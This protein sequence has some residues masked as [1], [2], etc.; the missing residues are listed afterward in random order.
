MVQVFIK[1]E[2]PAQ[3]FSCAICET[4]KNIFFAEHFRATASEPIKQNK[5]DVTLSL[6]HYT[7][8]CKQYIVIISAEEYSKMVTGRCPIKRC[9]YCK[10]HR[11][12][13]VPESLF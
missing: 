3:V 12:V 2:S 8:P 4:F 9:S 13:P 1:K 5:K 6:T 11:K 7:S 10:I